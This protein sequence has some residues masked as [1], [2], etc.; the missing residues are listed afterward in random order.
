MN[1]NKLYVGLFV[2]GMI[3]LSLVVALIMTKNYHQDDSKVRYQLTKDYKDFKDKDYS[4]DLIKG[5]NLYI[6]LCSQC[7]KE[8]GNGGMKGAKLNQNSIL[9]HNQNITQILIKGKKAMPSYRMVKHEDLANI[10]NYLREFAPTKDNKGE[11]TILD[12]IT[13]K[14]EALQLK[15]LKLKK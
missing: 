14:V 2:G 13:S 4:V 10:A 1:K 11:I 8:D 12:I 5:K 9:N 3:L 7:H 6:Q 15:E